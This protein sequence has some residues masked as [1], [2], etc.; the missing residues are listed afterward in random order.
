MTVFTELCW[1]LQAA[2][3]LFTTL[4]MYF[5]INSQLNEV[6]RNEF[7]NAEKHVENA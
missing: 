7:V 3:D 6:K 4:T 5:S 2:N 1:S